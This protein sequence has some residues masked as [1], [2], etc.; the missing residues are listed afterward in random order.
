L[1]ENKE[2]TL[3]MCLIVNQAFEEKLFHRAI[4]LFVWLLL[5]SFHL[6]QENLDWESHFSAVTKIEKD[7]ASLLSCAKR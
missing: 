6:M 4:S 7:F 3:Q 2:Q 1:R 5:Q